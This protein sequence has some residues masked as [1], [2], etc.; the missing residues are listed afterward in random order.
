MRIRFTR[1]AIYETEGL[2]R[3]P[4]FSAG[5]VHDMRQDQAER[6]VRRGVAQIEPDAVEPEPSAPARDMRARARAA[7]PA[8]DA[9]AAE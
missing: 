1:D 3:G 7:Q 6:W 8:P 5:E 2:G 4:R 9:L